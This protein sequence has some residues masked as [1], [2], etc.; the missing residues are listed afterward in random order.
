[1]SHCGSPGV[2]IGYLAKSGYQSQKLH[3][4]GSALLNKQQTKK[5]SSC[6][7]VVICTLHEKVNNVK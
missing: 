4:G 5:L 7:A 6:I 1:M 2:S 3:F